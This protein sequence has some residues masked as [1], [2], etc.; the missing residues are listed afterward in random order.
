ME[1]KREKYNS[2]MRMTMVF[3]NYWFVEGFKQVELLKLAWTV[4]T[5]EEALLI[6]NISFSSCFQSLFRLFQGSHRGRA[7]SDP[8]R[9]KNTQQRDGLTDKN[10]TKTST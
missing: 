5:S 6:Q 4:K 3:F 1:R 10:L 9:T 8:K 2:R 7:P